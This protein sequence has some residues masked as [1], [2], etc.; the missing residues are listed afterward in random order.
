MAIGRDNLTGEELWARLPLSPDSYPQ[1]LDLAR[2]RVLTIRLDADTYRSASFLDDRILTPATQGAWFPMARIAEAAA[3]VADP[4]R[5]HF[6]FHAGHTGSTLV[7]RL[8]DETGEVLP[9]REPLPLRS[10]ADAQEALGKPESLLSE[11]GFDSTLGA[12]LRL[13]SR[14][15]DWTRA[16]VVK[17]TSSAGTLAVPLL[18]LQRDAQAVWLNLGAEPYLATLLSGANSADDLRG[19]GPGRI[20]RLQARCDAPQGPLHALGTGELAALGWVAGKLAERDALRHHAARILPVDFDAFLG[21]VVDWTGRILAHLGLGA[22][23]GVLPA[24]KISR[25][26]ARYSKAPDR[27]YSPEDRRALI[28]AARRDQ[29]AEIRAGLAW[30]DRLRRSEPRLAR[31]LDGG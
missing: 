19:H 7:S 8:L 30:I 21:D 11:T 13:W 26:M 14:G 12:F 31:D 28:A 22:D 4:R 15:Y 17:A 18:G 24:T 3:R 29:T 23:R 9:I 10:L 20:R 2:Q 25:V 6:V 1:K 16:V 27:S 5:L